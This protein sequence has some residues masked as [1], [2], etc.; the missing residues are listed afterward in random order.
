MSVLFGL[1]AGV[2]PRAWIF[3]GAA[4]A[5][6]AGGVYML[7][8]ER[9]AGGQAAVARIEKANK[10]STDAANKAMDALERCYLSGGNW[11]RFTRLCDNQRSGQ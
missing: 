2:S 10:E 7:N 6:V 1:L 8:A 4:A 9:Q 11:D 5:I 3:L